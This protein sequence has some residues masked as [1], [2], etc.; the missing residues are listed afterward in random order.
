MK[1]HEMKLQPEYY[2]Y[3]KTGTKIIELRLN[4][5][6][7]QLIEVGDKITFFKEPNLDES[8]VATVTELLHYSSFT[9]LFNDFDISLLA[10]KSMTK[11][12][13]LATLEKFYTP[14]KQAK[15]GVLGIKI[16]LNS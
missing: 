2:N 8:F 7:R 3:M 11:Q 4:D 15:Y 1:T 10:D 12:E 16:K 5:E 14:E 13:L 9:E 6:K